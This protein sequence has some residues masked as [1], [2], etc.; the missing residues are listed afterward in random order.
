MNR[1]ILCFLVVASLPVTTD[2]S[3]G[4]DASEESAAIRGVEA[5]QAEA[6]NRHDAR[7]YAA[8]FTEDADVVNVVG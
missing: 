6:W 1:A 5:R 4:A 2:R 7:A 3:F 8:L